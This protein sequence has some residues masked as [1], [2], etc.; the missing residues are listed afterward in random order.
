[1][2][3]FDKER[4]DELVQSVAGLT[5]EEAQNAFSKSIVK[6]L[7]FNIKTIID[8]KRQI[9]AR[10]EILEY[11]EPTVTMDDVGGLGNLITW[12]EERKLAFGFLWSESH[13]RLRIIGRTISSQ[14]APCINGSFNI[15]FAVHAGYEQGSHAEI[16][17][18]HP[19]DLLPTHR[20]SSGFLA[21]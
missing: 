17:E 1:M 21:H 7:S 18:T 9:I 16:T 5:L 11:C 2:I 10:R 8:I 4:K 3:Y 12:F 14:K 13:S 19:I 6:H 20:C 15:T